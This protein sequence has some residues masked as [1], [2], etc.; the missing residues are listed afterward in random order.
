MSFFLGV[1]T[2]IAC[3]GAVLLLY[4]H[5]SQASFDKN[6]NTSDNKI[7]TS[8][9]EH[10]LVP[11]SKRALSEENALPEKK[12]KK[13]KRKKKRKSAP[14]PPSSA[15]PENYP[16]EPVYDRPKYVVE[17][18]S[19]SKPTPTIEE[20]TVEDV[21]MVDVANTVEVSISTG[22]KR[23][24]TEAEKNTLFV[25]VESIRGT[26]FEVVIREELNKI[27]EE[28]N[29]EIQSLFPEPAFKSP[30]EGDVDIQQLALFPKE[31]L[32]ELNESQ[33]NELLNNL[34]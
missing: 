1:V 7:N 20:N 23:P 31:N 4:L 30:S 33:K 6:S 10:I 2:S 29:E 21:N 18:S 32:H 3:I 25:K 26:H 8:N 34:L 19:V 14:M 5:I 24:L 9:G 22:K 28:V 17:E 13:K 11:S 27:Q 12:K 15:T 16:Y